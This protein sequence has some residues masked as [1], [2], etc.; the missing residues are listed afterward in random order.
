[1]SDAKTEHGRGFVSL[2]HRLMLG[3]TEVA[4]IYNLPPA[5]FC[6]NVARP[7]IENAF[8]PLSVH[9][10]D[11]RAVAMMIEM[12]KDAPLRTAEPEGKA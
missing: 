2:L 1:M 6:D 9:Y 7:L 3:T 12:V 5:D 10:G 4:R 11:E 8:V